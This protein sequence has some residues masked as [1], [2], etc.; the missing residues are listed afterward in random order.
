V[1]HAEAPQRPSPATAPGGAAVRG[2]PYL[3]A[4]ISFAAVF[5]LVALAD[6]AVDTPGRWFPGVTTKEWSPRELTVTRG[7]GGV[8]RDALVVAASAS[9]VL[10][11]LDT[12][13]R[14]ADYPV[15]SWVATNVPENVEARLLWR[16]DYAPSRLNSAAIGVAAGQL[17]PVVVAGNPNWVGRIRGLALAINGPTGAPIRIVGVSAKPMG[18]L[19]IAR[20]RLAEWTAFEGT[21]GTLIDGVNGGANVQ[22][23][24]LPMLLAVIVALASLLWFSFARFRSRA[25]ALPSVLAALFVAAWFADD[26]RWAWNVL[27]QTLATS[28]TYAGLD[29]RDR[30]LAAEDGALFKFIEAARAKLPPEPARVF[31]TADAHYFRGRGAYH[32]YPHNVY[33]EPYRNTIPP[34]PEMRSGDYFVVYQRRGVQYDSAAQRLRWD[35]GEAVSAELLLTAPGA[36]LFRIR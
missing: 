16:N 10:V 28:R 3:E 5:A 27:R 21:S 36:A 34:S 24:P 12:D 26:V 29:W 32:L 17:L 6:V 35:G 30:H 11:G 25:L 14:A 1:E 9:T 19:D 8:D 31:M 13:I 4:L 7:S 22:S 33:F 18:A 15:I 23:L 20:D 2:H